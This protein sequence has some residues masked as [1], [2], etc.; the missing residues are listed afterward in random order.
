LPA[1]DEDGQSD[2]FVKIWDTSKEEKKT[3]VIEDNNNP[4]FYETLELKME[5]ASM[6]DLP[7]FVLDIYDKDTLSNDFICRTLIPWKE[8]AISLDEKFV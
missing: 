5:A 7:P 2:P 4:L 8:A 1:A 6:E 3:R